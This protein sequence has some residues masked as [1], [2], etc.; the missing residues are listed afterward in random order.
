MKKRKCAFCDKPATRVLTPMIA[1][2]P[3]EAQGDLKYV[4]IG[5]N[6]FVCDNHTLD[7]QDVSIKV[8][9]KYEADLK[10]PMRNK[11]IADIPHNWVDV[12]LKNP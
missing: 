8:F 12:R 10:H 9:C 2:V 11:S 7:Y 4:S 3:K 1:E 5:S 6:I